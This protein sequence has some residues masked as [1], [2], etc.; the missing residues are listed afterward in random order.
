MKRATAL[1]LLLCLLLAAALPGQAE[2]R[3][4]RCRVK[5]I[6]PLEDWLAEYA[7]E[8]EL[9]N[10]HAD[11]ALSTQ[12][13]L[14]LLSDAEGPDLLMLI[15]GECDLYQ[16]LQSG[17]LE[18]LSDCEQVRLGLSQMYQP[19]QDLVAG[20]GGEI[21]GVPYGAHG[22]TMQAVPSAWEA[23]EL[24]LED[25]PQSFTELLDFA[26]RWVTLVEAGSVENVC[27]NTMQVGNPNDQRR[28]ILWLMDLLQVSWSMD[29]QAAGEAVRF[30]EP[31]FAELA[32]RAREIGQAL[33][34][35]EER[36]GK[37]TLSLYN[38]R[39]NGSMGY[40][41]DALYSNAF[42]MRLEAE[43]PARVKGYTFLF[44]VRKGSPYADLCKEFL[45][46]L[47]YRTDDSQRNAT[48]YR[49]IPQA[50]FSLQEDG[51]TL[52]Q[53]WVDVYR[54][55]QL[56]FLCEPFRTPGAIQQQES[57]MQRFADGELTPEELAAALDQAAQAK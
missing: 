11:E 25:A 16:V 24:D 36:P 5:G 52:T 13:A 27:L 18:D 47:A 44:V 29:Q 2:E 57:L 45:G 40:G 26:E 14:E 33:A 50:Q 34:E 22:I 4:L 31:A 12:D 51:Y 55:E 21:Y 54:P 19:F 42:P 32:G 15:S 7:P 30:D 8:V 48:L 39:R 38:Y 41:E 49:D 10:P 23:A 43:D 35:V 28:Y 1:C 3:P 17:L 46:D 9:E 56:F 37:S 53:A 20:S 6:D